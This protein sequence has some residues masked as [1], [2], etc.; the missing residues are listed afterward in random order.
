MLL[1]FVYIAFAF[2][3]GFLFFSSLCC[4]ANT[5]AKVELGINHVVIVVCLQ[6]RTIKLG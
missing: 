6:S 3:F 2:A 4:G 1:G 5:Q